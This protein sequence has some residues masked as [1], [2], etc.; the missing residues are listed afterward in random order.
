MTYLVRNL[1]PF[2]LLSVAAH[3]GASPLFDDN[4]VIDVELTGPIGSLIRK[5]DD[6]TEVPFVLKANGVEQQVQV[7]VRGKSRLRICKFPPLR[8][9]FSDSDT[10]QTVFAGQDKIKLITHCRSNNASQ[11][12][13][14]QEYA[15]YRIFNI[16]SDIGY[17]VRLLHITYRDTDERRKDDLI[18]RYGFLLESQSALAARVG[19]A[20]VDVTGISLRSLDEDHAA[21]VYIFQYLIGNTDW[22]FVMADGD[23]VCCHNG[24]ILD[25]DSTRYYVP[26]DFDLVGLVNSKY[27][28]PDPSLPIRKVTQR[29]YVGFC[30][31]RDTLQSALGIIK[32]HKEEI[33][34]VLSDIPGLP[35]KDRNRSIDFLTQFF[36]RADDE[37]KMLKS[38][39]KRCH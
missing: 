15:V 34:G 36:T 32:S 29:Y 23:D 19:G 11:V 24:D 22:S 7:R 14:L 3:A 16:I 8:L 37:E 38:F 25:I 21:A 33:L 26:Y 6:S 27:A 13:A 9:N 35:E 2:A 18:E 4:A 1:L 12:D 30:T 5:K 17:R 10:E 39:E 31:S 20:P 28:Y